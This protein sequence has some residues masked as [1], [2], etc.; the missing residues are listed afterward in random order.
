MFCNLFYTTKSRLIKI[1]NSREK[2]TVSKTILQFEN[3]KYRATPV[4]EP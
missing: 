3:G 2:G 1:S 4:P